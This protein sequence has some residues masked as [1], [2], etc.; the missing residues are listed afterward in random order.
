MTDVDRHA[1]NEASDG[2][3]P[4]QG[5]SNRRNLLRAGLFAGVAAVGATTGAE[6]ISNPAGAT[7]GDPVTID[8]TTTG[9]GG[10]TILEY[11]SGSNTLGSVLRA[12]LQDW[13]GQVYNVMA[14]GATGNGST[15]DT[16]AIAAAQQAAGAGCVLFPAGTYQ[17]SGLAI[18][19]PGQTFKLESGATI[20][21]NA[22]IAGPVITI[23]AASVTI[24]GP[25]TIDGNASAQS[26][27]NGLDCLRF[28]AGADDGLVHGLV[29]Q[30]AAWLGIETNGAARTRIV[31]NRVLNCTHGGISCNA[32]TA[33]I[34][35]P[36]IS[37]N[38]VFLTSGTVISGI[39]VQGPSSTT[40][41]NYADVSDNQVEVLAGLGYQVSNCNY[42][43]VVGNRGKG[44]SQ[45]FSVVGGSDNLVSSNSALATGTGA[46]IELGSNYSTCVGNTVAVSGTGAGIHADNINGTHVIIANNKITGSINCGIGVGSY[47]HVTVTGNIIHQST[48]ASASFSVIQVS[49]ANAGLILIADNICDAAGASSYGIWL[50]NLTSTAVQTVIHD[51]AITGVPTASSNA[52]FRFAG[53]GTLTDLL[54][55]DNTIGASIPVYSMAP[56]LS[57]GSNVRFSR[58]IIV[59]GTAAGLGVTPVTLPPSGTAYANPGPYSEV[60]YI[61]GGKLVPGTGPTTGVVKNGHVLVPGSVVLKTP[62]SIVLDPGESLTVYYS[63]APTAWKDV[64]G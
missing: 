42:T 29:A 3:N 46:G 62:V 27:T 44:P 53:A 61:Q 30:N 9:A 45:V 21:A 47:D 64:K 22:S 15:D 17:V 40:N 19:T 7:P 41:V 4:V 18:S 1:T 10:T 25:G 32:T 50:N 63:V 31:L 20:R 23:S 6:L 24:L 35:G 59:G 55:H 28:T 57:F 11:T 48:S 43:R 16:A 37:G 52:A 51:N 8:E 33:T 13:G 34:D 38:R 60:V 14:Y 5:W 56:G 58:N 36:L 26:G 54:V 39:N 12:A 49:P 2:E